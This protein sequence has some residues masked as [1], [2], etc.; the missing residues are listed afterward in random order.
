MRHAPSSAFRLLRHA[1]LALAFTVLCACAGQRPLTQAQQALAQAA[2][3]A[4]AIDLEAEA[5][6]DGGLR[7]GG[8]LQGHQFA[9][10]VPA[11]WNRQ[12]MLFAHG[13]SPPGTP[14]AV[15]E[16]PMA[17]D[18]DANGVFRTPYAQGFAVGHSAYDKAGMDVRGAVEN[19]H[20]LAQFV[21]R[22]G[23]S[24]TYLVGASMGGNIV[25]AL[26]DKH[27]RDFA[28]AIAA[29]GVVGDWPSELGW[30]NDVRAAYN[31]F[32]QGTPYAL[33]GEHDITRSALSSPSFGPWRM[34]QMRRL[35][36]PVYALFD[37]DKAQP[38]GQA[39][40]IIDNIVA[41][42]DTPR[43]AASFGLPILT[44]GL[45]MDDFN[46]SFGGQ[47]FDNTQR[48]Y[49]SPHLDAAGNA[50]LNAGIQR[51][52]ANPAAVAT[53][54]AW[55]KPAGRLPV[56]LLTLYNQVDPLVPSGP[57]EAMLRAAMDAAGNQARLVQRAVP[58]M[59]VPLPASD[60]QGLAHCGFTPQQT[61][62]AWNDL[63]AWV[64][65][66]VRPQP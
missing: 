46:A 25:V 2:R 5:R 17:K 26:L 22:L 15:A 43:D 6:E 12:A 60:L 44:S 10:I 1:L 51:V 18:K 21:A 27:P 32:T 62:R 50:R 33:P 23:A 39:S 52:A 48:V 13:Y 4:G 45:G 28:G 57:N 36:K 29:C 7:L 31:Y 42:A 11:G 8:R 9:L 37:A 61:A 30:I 34:W 53:A 20:R 38:G 56:P 41:V 14:V 49:R 19:T 59:T 40:R 3:T 16:D 54:N 24:R 35:A 64:E 65:T 47:I 58:P 63:R 66:G 55:V